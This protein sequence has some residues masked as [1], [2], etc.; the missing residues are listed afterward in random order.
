MTTH[1]F[2]NPRLATQATVPGQ[3]APLLSPCLS[4]AVAPRDS[5]LLSS[6]VQA[7]VHCLAPSWLLLPLE[8]VYTCSFPSGPC[9]SGKYRLTLSSP[10]PTLYPAFMSFTAHTAPV[11]HSLQ[12]LFQARAH[13]HPQCPLPGVGGCCVCRQ[14]SPLAPSG[15]Q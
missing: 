11:D 13:T 1:W 10:Q 14:T 12:L 3:D 7:L 8:E 5:E 15:W 2:P 9:P 4:G 6:E